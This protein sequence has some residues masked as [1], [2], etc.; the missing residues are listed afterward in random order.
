MTKVLKTFTV[1][2]IR[3]RRDIHLELFYFLNNI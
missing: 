1:P 2:N 3:L